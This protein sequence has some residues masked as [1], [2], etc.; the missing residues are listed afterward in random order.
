MASIALI[1]PRKRRVKSRKARKANPAGKT[2]KVKSRRRKSNPISSKA[3]RSAGR[4]LRKYKLSRG[5]AKRRANPINMGSLKRM[6]IPALTGAAGAILVDQ[7]YME[8]VKRF[9][10]KLPTML[11]GGF[12]KA[13]TEVVIAFAV[14]MALEKT[15]LV[16]NAQTRQALMMGALTGI[17]I[18]TINELVMPKLR[19]ATGTATA[20]YQLIDS[21]ALNGYQ[22]AIAP[23][24]GLASL[25]YQGDAPAVGVMSNVRNFRRSR[26]F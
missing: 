20:G 19:A 1:N 23:T 15:K 18:T 7:L 12:G 14:N 8:L 25:G 26:T 9:G 16:K 2:R 17:G 13:V 24:P 4:T 10:S 21:T 3:L 22:G 11:Q 5:R 6:A